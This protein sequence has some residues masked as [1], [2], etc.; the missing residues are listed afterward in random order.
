MTLLVLL[1]HG[2]TAGNR[3]H[4][5]QGRTDPPLDAAGRTVV[6]SWRLPA[7]ARTLS[8]RS[9]PLRRCTETA[10][11]LDIVAEAEPHLIEMDW[12]A[13]EGRTL[14]SLRA[15]DP[16]FAAE[17][18]RGLDLN[19]PDGESP[20]QVQARLAE[21]FR[22]TAAIGADVGAISHKGIIRVTLALATG[23]DMLGKPPV[24]LRWDALHLFRLNPTGELKIERLNYGLVPP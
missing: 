14:A 17:E 18:A 16:R 15:E 13:W 19:P 7:F 20:R 2:P 24:R 5:L 6:A 9:S 4:R 10:D 1:R 23:W 11:L 3:E 8:W 21:F 12:G 22:E